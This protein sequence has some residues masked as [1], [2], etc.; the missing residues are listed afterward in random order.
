MLFLPSSP[1]KSWQQFFRICCR[2][3]SMIRP[4]KESKSTCLPAVIES[5]KRAVVYTRGQA[6]VHAEKQ[7][8]ST[9]ETLKFFRAQW[10]WPLMTFLSVF[11]RF[12]VGA[13]WKR[14]E[15]FWCGEVFLWCNVSDSPHTVYATGQVQAM[16]CAS[17][18]QRALHTPSHLILTDPVVVTLW[19]AG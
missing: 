1:S 18:F 11:W 14:L 5:D 10:H 17:A 2:K 3:R 4:K 16:L 7:R 12:R 8:Y 19:S 6:C 9:K 13:Q 15:A